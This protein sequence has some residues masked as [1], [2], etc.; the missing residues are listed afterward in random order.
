MLVIF[1]TPIFLMPEC[2]T[3]SLIE[4]KKKKKQPSEFLLSTTSFSFHPTCQPIS[5]R[6]KSHLPPSSFF[7]FSYN[8]VPHLQ[9]QGALQRQLFTPSVET[10]LSK[11]KKA[12]THVNLADGK[13]R[14]LSDLPIHLLGDLGQ[15]P[16]HH[17]PRSPHLSNGII[18][19]GE[20]PI[21]PSQVH[22]ATSVG[23][24]TLLA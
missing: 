4:K 16:T 23:S 8:L 15:I 1:I 9:T 24:S 20:Q 6:G 3:Q 21:A 12:E 18:T 11:A 10:S 7:L 19:Q 13:P 2:I 17:K 5:P 14:F 22:Q